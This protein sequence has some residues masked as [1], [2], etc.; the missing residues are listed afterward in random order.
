MN[1]ED[2]IT[3]LHHI[4]SSSCVRLKPLTE[5]LEKRPFA[6]LDSLLIFVMGEV[7]SLIRRPSISSYEALALGSRLLNHTYPEGIDAAY[8]D[9]TPEDSAYF[10]RLVLEQFHAEQVKSALQAELTLILSTLSWQE[11]LALVESIRK[12][13]HPLLFEKF[14]QAPAHLFVENLPELLIQLFETDLLMKRKLPSV[15]SQSS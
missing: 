15:L 2:I 11:Q 1:F 8:L 6:R 12:K 14:N 4:N 5:Q 3:R 10:G 7:S 13:K 9:F